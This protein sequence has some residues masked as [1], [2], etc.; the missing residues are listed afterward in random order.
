[1]VCSVGESKDCS[2][3]LGSQL[4]AEQ[5]WKVPSLSQ[6]PYLFYGDESIAHQRVILCIK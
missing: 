5:Q 4:A 6:F 3:S 1:V 2:K